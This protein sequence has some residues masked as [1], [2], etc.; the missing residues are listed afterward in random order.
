M[1]RIGK[2]YSF[3]IS[4]Y[5]SDGNDFCISDL[6]YGNGHAKDRRREGNG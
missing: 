2:D 4:S 1:K 3:I 6:N 5:G